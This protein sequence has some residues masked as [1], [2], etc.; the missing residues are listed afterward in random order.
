MVW[1]QERASPQETCPRPP[2]TPSPEYWR[3]PQI[4][5]DCAEGL[6]AHCA[7]GLSSAEKNLPHVTITD[8]SRALPLLLCLA[9][10]VTPAEW[11]WWMGPQQLRV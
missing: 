8:F 3:R 6:C 2:R 7:S 4:T 11:P 9:I 5:R 1:R 10:R